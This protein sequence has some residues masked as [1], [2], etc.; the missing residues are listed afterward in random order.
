MVKGRKFVVLSFLSAFISRK[1][2]EISLK[3]CVRKE[4]EL[5]NLTAT[6]IKLTVEGCG[7]AVEN[8]QERVEGRDFFWV[9]F[10]ENL[11]SQEE[12]AKLLG[13][14][15]TT[16]WRWERFVIEPAPVIA[17]EYFSLDIKVIRRMYLSNYQRF[18]LWLIFML[19]SGDSGYIPVTNEGVTKVLTMGFQRTKRKNFENWINSLKKER[20]QDRWAC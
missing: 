20:G 7:L 15:R 6:N 12:T 17:D 1:D 13:I 5:S 19:K 3:I 14:S 18:I 11:L 9:M 4:K 16:V 8:I 10:G 2:K